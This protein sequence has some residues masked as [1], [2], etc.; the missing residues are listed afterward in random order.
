MMARTVSKTAAKKPRMTNWMMAAKAAEAARTAKVLAVRSV[1]AQGKDWEPKTRRT[2]G[3]RRTI[4]RT[5]RG[6]ERKDTCKNDPAKVARKCC[7]SFSDDCRDRVGRAAW[8][9]VTPK[10]E[11]GMA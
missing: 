6:R 4:K 10:R 5:D 8:P 1:A 7:K 11:E 2:M 9:M 3:I